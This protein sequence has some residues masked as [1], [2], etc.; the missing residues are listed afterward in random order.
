MK[1]MKDEGIAYGAFAVL[2]V[3]SFL[4][5]A[6]LFRSNICL[7]GNCYLLVDEKISIVYVLIADLTGFRSDT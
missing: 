1:V 3:L 5:G 7:E 2:T 6:I 4:V